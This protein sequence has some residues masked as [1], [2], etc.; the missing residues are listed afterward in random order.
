MVIKAAD[1]LSKTK[2]KIGQSIK[3]H[4]TSVLLEADKSGRCK[5]LFM[6]YVFLCTTNVESDY[7]LPR[8]ELSANA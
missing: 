3:T 4:R 8:P 2:R 1:F 5:T 6:F 7:P